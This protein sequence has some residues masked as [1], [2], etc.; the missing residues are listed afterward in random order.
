MRASTGAALVRERLAPARRGTVLLVEPSS[1]AHVHT[2][3]P[4]LLAGCECLAAA[5]VEEA[6]A[7][8][9][10]TRPVMTLVDAALFDT[11]LEAE[12][13]ERLCAHPAQAGVPLV[14]LASTQTPTELV[15]SAWRAG[16]TDCLV[17]PVALP[18]VQE[19][20]AA[21]AGEGRG[22]A[23]PVRRAA[24]RV[25]LVVDSDADFRQ[26]LARLLGLAGYRLLLAGSELEAQARVAQHGGA[27]DA[28]VVRGDPVAPGLLGWLLS[29]DSLRLVP[30]LRVEPLVAGGLGQSS[31]L[32][33]EA[34][35]PGHVL[36]WVD[37]ALQRTSRELRVHEAVPFFC[38]V[39]FRELGGDG[40]WH[41]GFS[42]ELSPGGLFI[43]TLVPPRTGAALELKILLT[44]NGEHLEGSG[45]VAWS[46][47]W[48]SSGPLCAPAGMG[49]QFLGM[50][51]RGL[52]RLRSLCCASF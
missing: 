25:V 52:A 11:Y 41:S 9:E 30:T 47:P 6:L 34:T 46:N 31:V 2:V 23:L 17:R 42:S 48:S 18:H 4:V 26:E 44:T 21:L 20:L 43:R 12:P 32:A 16:A 19:R 5:S 13:L 3:P 14:V 37:S 8:L 40:R 29:T 27:V 1:Q 33:R 15:E 51:P 39:A 28:V 22:T 49:V 36:A 38:P 45:V 50:S 7:H 35:S 24:P 10:R